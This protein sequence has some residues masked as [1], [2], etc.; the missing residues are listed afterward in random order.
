VLVSK[1]WLDWDSMNAAGEY[2]IM[3]DVTYAAIADVQDYY[4][5]NVG[6]P[7]LTP[8]RD[9]EGNFRPG[10]VGDYYPIDEN[11]YNYIMQQLPDKPWW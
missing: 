7:E 11:T 2:G 10:G 5:A 3:G 4:A 6:M 8:V 1:G 9:Y